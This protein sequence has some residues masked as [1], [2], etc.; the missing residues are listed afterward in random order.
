MAKKTGNIYLF[1]LIISSFFCLAEQAEIFLY[2]TDLQG[3]SFEFIKRQQPFM[4]H[5][6]VKNMPSNFRPPAEIPGTKTCVVSSAGVANSISIVNG[7]RNETFSH[8]Y[9][10]RGTKEGEFTFGPIEG[11]AA[12]GTKIVSNQVK[13]IV[14]DHRLV[15]KSNQ[16]AFFLEMSTDK[17]NVYVNEKVLLTIRFYYRHN[18]DQLHIEEP[19]YLD[20]LVGFKSTHYKP[21]KKV[22]DGQDFFYK[23]MTVNLYPKKAGKI[24]LLPARA[25]FSDESSSRSMFDALIHNFLSARKELYSEAVEINVSSLPEHPQGKKIN[26]VGQ[27]SDFSLTLATDTEAVGKPVVAKYVIVGDGSVE[28]I[29][30]PDVRLPESIHFY[31]SSDQITKNVGGKLERTFEVI[32]QGSK[33]GS[34]TIPK[35]EFIYFDTTSKKYKTLYTEP[36][37]ITFTGE[38]LPEKEKNK[39]EDDSHKH[40]TIAELKKTTFEFKDWQINSVHQSNSIHKTENWI[41]SEKLFLFLLII[42]LIGLF[43][44]LMA[45]HSQQLSVFLWRYLVVQKIFIYFSLFL[46]KQLPAKILTKEE[47]VYILFTRFF[48]LSGFDIRKDFGRLFLQSIDCS[49]EEQVEWKNYMGQLMHVMYAQKSGNTSEVKTDS[50][51]FYDSAQKMFHLFFIK[52]KQA[53]KR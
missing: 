7:V 36:V 5:V 19:H 18:F 52:I 14:S 51:D 3:N 53:R 25:L 12:D 23:E 1:L 33:P 30:R 43:L 31:S 35:H 29:S 44:W 22:I 8:N 2:V 26:A 24:D 13:V 20:F 38:A 39:I 10:I 9:V 41:M 32:I 46:I 42:L 49:E 48:E 4:L 17:K 47:K 40:E 11:T 21:G 15:H 34:F 27:F 16:E 6:Q 28:M 37:E 45:L 50:N